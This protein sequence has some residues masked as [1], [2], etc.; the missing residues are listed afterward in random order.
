MNNFKTHICGITMAGKKNHLTELLE[1]LYPYYDALQWT[2]HRPLDEGF[3]YLNSIKKEGKIIDIDFYQRLDFSRNISLFG[4]TMKTGDFM[5]ILD[6]LERLSYK[7]FD[8]WPSFKQFLV[9]NNIDGV[10]L[11]GKRF[12]Y[13]YNEFLEYKGNPH[14]YLY[15][16]YKLNIIELTNLEPF[17]D[18]SWFWGSV[19]NINRDKYH[20]V[21]HYLKYFLYPNSNHCWLGN[22]Q[23]PEIYQTEETVRRQFRY[24]LEQNNFLPLTKDKFIW[25]CNYKLDDIR[26]WLNNSKILND[27]Y[28]YLVL[29]KTDFEDD[30]NYSNKIII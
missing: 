6:D 3:D 24:Y 17:K 28:R 15:S 8:L 9:Q 29:N 2:F 20:F 12:L 26:D 7:F 1:P 13:R 18:T 14:E 23:K 21:E 19:R 10:L 22:E 16:P 30:H 27:A 5:F 25:L 11:Y 4:G